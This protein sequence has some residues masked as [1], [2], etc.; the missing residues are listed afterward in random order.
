[1]GATMTQ[2]TW[3][4]FAWSFVVLT[5]CDV[6]A[7]VAVN[8]QS[9]T[10]AAV[11]LIA[12]AAHHSPTHMW[13]TITGFQSLIAVA[14]LFTRTLVVALVLQYLIVSDG[15]ELAL[16]HTANIAVAA[17]FV[18]PLQ[19]LSMVVITSLELSTI[20][21]SSHTAMIPGS[22][23]QWL[24]ARGTTSSAVLSATNV[25]NPFEIGW[26]AIILHGLRQDTRL[27]GNAF[28]NTVLTWIVAVSP[29]VAISYV[30]RLVTHR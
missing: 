8:E 29:G 25:I 13:A 9:L 11:R 26:C 2:A 14:Y 12:G 23:A 24:V 16:R 30:A 7:I 20:T 3:R 21:G 10:P 27:V 19:A 1:M 15:I 17:N 22:L 4:S 28:R 6:L 18:I 5:L